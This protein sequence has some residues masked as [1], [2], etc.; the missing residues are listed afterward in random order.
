[1]TCVC[2]HA[3]VCACACMFVGSSEFMIIICDAY[4]V[5]TLFLRK[6]PQELSCT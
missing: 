5:G 3:C 2:V 1:M 4:V 6:L